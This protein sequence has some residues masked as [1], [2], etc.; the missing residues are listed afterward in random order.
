VTLFTNVGGVSDGM[1][2][3][4]NDTTATDIGTPAPGD[5]VPIV[6]NYNLEGAALLS[7]FNGLDAS[8]EW[9]LSITD[10]FAANSGTLYSWSLEVTY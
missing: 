1:F 2:V 7:I 8:G 6:G 4:L 3:R 9:V 10:D 5:G